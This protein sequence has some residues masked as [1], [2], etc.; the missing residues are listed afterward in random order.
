M[1]KRLLTNT[2]LLKQGYHGSG[3]GQEQLILLESGKSHEILEFCQKSRKIKS[4]CQTCMISKV[5]YKNDVCSQEMYGYGSLLVLITPFIEYV[6]KV[7]IKIIFHHSKT[8]C[9]IYKQS[10]LIDGC[11]GWWRPYKSL[12]FDVHRSRKTRI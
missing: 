5:K 1:F 12:C 3:K 7:T 8:H 4:K 6:L 11:E 9:K 10:I 2:G